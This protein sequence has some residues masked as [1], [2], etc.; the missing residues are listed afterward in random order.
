MVKTGKVQTGKRLQPQKL[1][2]ILNDSKNVIDKSSRIPESK[3]PDCTQ[4]IAALGFQDNSPVF[5]A[6][7]HAACPLCMVSPGLLVF[8]AAGRQSGASE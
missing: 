6:L 7:S 4:R 5:P 1:I 8:V 2:K 3:G